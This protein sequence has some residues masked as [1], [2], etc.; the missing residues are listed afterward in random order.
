[1]CTNYTVL[2]HKLALPRKKEAADFK[3]QRYQIYTGMAKARCSIQR[4]S[5]EMSSAL[6]IVHGSKSTLEASR[7]PYRKLFGEFHI[8]VLNI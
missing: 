4:Q 1:M 7:K 3:L 5:L 2:P 6:R 8:P